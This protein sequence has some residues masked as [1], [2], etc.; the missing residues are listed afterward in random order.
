V[1]LKRVLNVPARGIGPTSI[2]RIEDFAAQNNITLWTALS[3]IDEIPDIPSKARRQVTAFVK[4]VEFLHQARRRYNVHRLMEEVLE[5]TGYIRALKDE[6]KGSMEA[7]SRVENVQELL[8]VAEEFVE[9]SEEPTLE[10]FLE[11]V[12]LVSDIDTYD[13]SEDAVT[14]MTL[15]AAKGLEF[16]VVFIVGMEEGLFPHRR[17]M[18]DSEEMEEERRLCYVGMTRAKEEL[19]LSYATQRMQMGNI[20]RQEKSRFLREIP[21][22][23]LSASSAWVGGPST[24][25][26]SSVEPKRSPG[27]STF[28]PGDKVSHAQFGTGIVLNSSGSGEDEQVTVAFDSAGVKKLVLAYA[29]LQKV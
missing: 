15:H 24:L 17:S 10:R 25:W 20:A 11:Q 1:S 29:K 14:L 27:A 18:G 21:S 2:S 12:A 28:R 5:N 3:R 8:S 13:E 23:L 22:E 19:H 4:L 9:S 26:R 16:P 7:E 6:G